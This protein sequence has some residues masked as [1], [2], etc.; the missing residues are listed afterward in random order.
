MLQE[1]QRNSTRQVCFKMSL[2]LKLNESFNTSDLR[3]SAGCRFDYRY[4]GK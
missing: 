3:G 2:L 4:L 1:K